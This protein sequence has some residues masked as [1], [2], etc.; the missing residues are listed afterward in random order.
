MYAAARDRLGPGRTLAVGDRLDIDIAGARR[1]G[2]DSALVLTGGT[3]RAEADAADPRP[4]H[5]ADSL[6]RS[7]HWASLDRPRDRRPGLPDRQSARRRRPR[8]AAAARRGGGAAR[9]RGGRSGSRRRCRCSTRAS[10]RGRRATTAR[11]APR[12]AATGSSARSPASCATAPGCWPCCP[13]GAGTTSRA[14]SG[15]RSTR[16]RPSALLEDGE[17]KRI[18][19]AEAD[20][21]DATSGSCPPGFDS[22]VSRIALETRLKLGTFVYTYGVLRAIAGW[23][24]A[25]WDVTIDGEPASF[26][27]LLG[28]GRELRRV[29]RRDV[30]RARRRAR[31]RPARGR[32]DLRA[33]RSC[34]TCAGCRACSTAP[35]CKDP[36][37]KLVQASEI[38]FSRRP[39][40]HRATPTATRSAT[41]R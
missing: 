1:A 27:R 32:H 12:W 35:T 2:L 6:P 26:E 13:A 28:R 17:E 22:D 9:R 19:L 31:R 5:V 24:Q 7:C 3:T 8:A 37:I 36:A 29:R 11:S 18:D 25:A 34:A 4:T 16:W 33:S 30:P 10:W 39:A 15:S 20:G 21:H 41:C 40:V 38:T 14:S 23:K